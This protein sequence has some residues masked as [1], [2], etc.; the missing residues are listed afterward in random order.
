MRG[1][2]LSDTI[3][4]IIATNKK[5]STHFNSGWCLET[6]QQTILFLYHSRTPLRKNEFSLSLFLV[7]A[8]SAYAP[9]SG[10]VI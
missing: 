2:L 8:E 4:F 9:P 5:L 1:N 6:S 7:P 3:L 10:L